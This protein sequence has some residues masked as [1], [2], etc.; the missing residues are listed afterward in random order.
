VH[1]AKGNKLHALPN[2]P[3]DDSVLS[4]PVIEEFLDEVAFVAERLDD[5][6]LIPWL[7]RLADYA[8][9]QLRSPGEIRLIISSN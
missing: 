2:R 3:A 5:D 7:Q 6:V 1:V 4:R 9:E 8:S